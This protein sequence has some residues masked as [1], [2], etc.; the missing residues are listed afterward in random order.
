MLE[1]YYYND[2]IGYIRINNTHPRVGFGLSIDG[3]DDHLSIGNQLFIDYLRTG[4]NMS[5]NHVFVKKSIVSIA[6]RD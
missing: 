5:F 1:K 3:A 2:Y 6:T 4:C